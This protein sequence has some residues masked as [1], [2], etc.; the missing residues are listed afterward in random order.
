[1]S[2]MS[3]YI[4]ILVGKVLSHSN[5]TS[6]C[7]FSTRNTDCMRISEKFSAC[8]GPNKFEGNLS[9][10]RAIS[11]GKTTPKL[12]FGPF[13]RLRPE[14]WSSTCKTRVPLWIVP[15]VDLKLHPY[16]FQKILWHEMSPW[17]KRP[18][19]TV[20]MSYYRR[21]LKNEKLIRTKLSFVLFMGASLPFSISPPCGRCLF[22]TLGK[23]RAG[24]YSKLTLLI[25][26]LISKWKALV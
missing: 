3:R 20:C 19:G 1:M 17:L 25:L 26:H 7:H 22:F 5:Y 2:A 18:F 24:P 23:F 8:G 9:T 15:R 12:I 13:V 14:H 16:V 6:I 11:K 21:P 4:E 10:E